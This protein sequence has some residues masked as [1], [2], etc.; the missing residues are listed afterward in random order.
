MTI[1]E[2]PNQSATLPQWYRTSNPTCSFIQ[3]TG[4]SLDKAGMPRATKLHYAPSGCGNGHIVHDPG[5]RRVP[6]PPVDEVP[7]EALPQWGGCPVCGETGYIAAGNSSEQ[8][9][10]KVPSKSYA[11]AQ[12][13]TYTVNIPSCYL[14]EVQYFMHELGLDFDPKRQITAINDVLMEASTAMGHHAPS[15][16][17]ALNHHLKERGLSPTV[18]DYDDNWTPEG[19]QEFLRMAV[20]KFHWVDDYVNTDWWEHDGKS[21]EDVVKEHPKVFGNPNQLC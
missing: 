6:Q 18:P 10:D 14:D 12:N 20:D 17:E 19:L 16:I 15:L 2:Q 8:T 4:V 11:T 3:V 5:A 1:T 9:G 21:W 13:L 7:A